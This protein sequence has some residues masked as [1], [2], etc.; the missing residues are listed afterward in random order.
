MRCWRRYWLARGEQAARGAASIAA[1]HGVQVVDCG[2]A[3]DG[4][5]DVQPRCCTGEVGET[6]EEAQETATGSCA[7]GRSWRRSDVDP[8]ARQKAAMAR[9]AHV[10][11]AV[12]ASRIEE[13]EEEA[14]RSRH[15]RPAT[16]QSWRKERAMDRGELGA[17]AD[18]QGA[19]REGGE[20]RGN[21]RQVG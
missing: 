21:R 6:R 10:R 15:R 4:A 9:K 18:E 7:R 13:V 12:R 2:A 14:R 19:E 5:G 8:A 1:A 16:D 17:A 3:A 11:S 20:R